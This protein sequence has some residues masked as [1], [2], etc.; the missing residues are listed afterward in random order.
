[1][2]KVEMNFKSIL[3]ELTPMLLALYE[4]SQ[5]LVAIYDD[6]DILR[7]ANPAFIK[8]VDTEPNGHSTWADMMRSNYAFERGAVINTDNFEHWLASAMSRRGKQPFRAFEADLRDG[9]WIWM[10]ETVNADGWMLNVASDIT[11]LKQNERELRQAHTIALRASQTDVLTG[12]SNRRHIMQLLEQALKESAE[13][14]ESLCVAMFDLDYFKSINDKFGHDIGDAVLCDFAKLLQASSRRQDGCG[15]IGGEEFMLV[16]PGVSLSLAQGIIERLLDIVRASVPVN[17]KPAL[18]YK[19]SVGLAG[20][21][22]GENM[23]SIMR[24]ADMALY[25]AKAAGRD[26]L[27]LADE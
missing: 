10:T 20:A 11:N 26:R 6:K 16:L 23:A 14:D 12:I 2:Q 3:D 13:R 19:T 27:E 21:R 5:L 8:A 22:K 7:Y 18:R 1:M 17:K 25:A 4:D 24:R 9:R 15:R